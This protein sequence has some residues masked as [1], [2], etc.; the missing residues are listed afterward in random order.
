MM[1]FV[2]TPFL[3]L[4]LSAIGLTVAEAV[5]F[6]RARLPDSTHS[7]QPP[8]WRSHPPRKQLSLPS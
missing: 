1:W 3:V 2:L 7:R 5:D 6:L 8:P 4:C